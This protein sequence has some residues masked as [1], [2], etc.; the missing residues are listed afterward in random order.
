MKNWN[1]DEKPLIID[2]LIDKITNDI[3]HKKD[4][5][6]LCNYLKE[7]IYIEDI[8]F[9]NNCSFHSGVNRLCSSVT[10]FIMKVTYYTN[11]SV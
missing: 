5:N 1:E 6:K 2:I 8:Q 9:L 7:S 11:Q 4:L 3:K 10:F